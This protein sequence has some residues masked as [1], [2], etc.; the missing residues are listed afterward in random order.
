MWQALDPLLT[1]DPAAR[2]LTVGDG[3]YGNDAKYIFDRGVW[4]LASDISDALLREAQQLG[5]I[6][7]FRKENAESLSFQDDEFDYVLCKESY[8]HFPRPIIALYEMLRVARKGVVLIEP[9]DVRVTESMRTFLFRKLIDLVRRIRR[10][11][12]RRNA[13]E[14][15]GNYVFTISRREIE[16][17]ALGLNYRTIAFLGL[18]DFFIS[19]V[20]N[21]K[22]SARGP[23]YRRTRNIITVLDT[24]CLTGFMDYKLLTALILKEEPSDALMRALRHA[25]YDVIPLPENPYV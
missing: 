10:E 13:F 20:E 8:H 5:R 22:I 9:N 2:W 18:N 25:K 21:E 11:P 17:V 19:G 14:P 16:K 24:L 3:C 7:Q 15:V 4:V 12:V 1:A 6:P 23:L